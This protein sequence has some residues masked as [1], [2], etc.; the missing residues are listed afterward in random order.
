MKAWKPRGPIGFAGLT[1]FIG[2]TRA[3]GANRAM[4]ACAFMGILGVTVTAGVLITG[5]DFAGG[6]TGGS[7][8][9]NGLT[10][11]LHDGDGKPVPQA[12]VV[13]LPDNYNPIPGRDARPLRRTSTDKRGLYR[14]PGVATGVYNL[15]AKDSLRHVQ[16]L[17][18]GIH[19][20]S[21]AAAATQADGV[22]E[23][24]GTLVIP[25]ADR[26]LPENAQAYV[27][28][29]TYCVFAASKMALGN[30]ALE[31]LAPGTYKELLAMSPDLPDG[32]PITVAGGFRIGPD[33]TTRLNPLQAWL[34]SARLKIDAARIPGGLTEALAGYPLL[35]R[36]G[37]SNFD[38]TQARGGGEDIRFTRA[39]GTRLPHQIEM[40]DAA[41]KTAAIWV[42]LDSLDRAGID[43][44]VTLH[45]GRVDAMDDSRGDQVFDTARGFA[46]V[47]HLGEPATTAAGAYHDATGE[48]AGANPA[49]A[50]APNADTR[51]AAMG[52]FGKAFS[53]GGG[54]LSAALPAGLGGNAG[55]SVTFWM[56]FEMT[57]GRA[58]ILTFG[59]PA[60]NRGFHFLIRADTSAQF[61]PWG[62]SPDSNDSPSAQQ[63]HF[64]LAPYL[65][66]WAQVATVYN[67]ADGML[68]TYVD[69]V[70]MASNAVPGMDIL[71]P[72]GLDIGKH[73]QAVSLLQS[74][75]LGSLDE[76]RVYRGAL[77]ES[78]IRTEYATQKEGAAVLL[79]P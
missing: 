10:G 4:A 1:G 13:L 35:V 8:T 33:S 71:A 77:S 50:A 74:D 5:C 12:A 21:A 48:A 15:E 22:L 53:P 42:R 49:T 25:F 6:T 11:T 58:G 59:Q 36:L 62:V 28:G 76:V 3:T 51:V 26:H 38:F 65:G 19:V 20:D 31:N 63:N 37:A 27:P 43:S 70:K 16:V 72:S 34:H 67:A 23:A 60:L 44:S 66:Q 69:G 56:R 2:L 68:T 7:E 55:F 17:V 54:T 52:G 47:W 9:T 39:D 78:W 30:L 18:Q 64:N 24:P 46:S 73:V 45:W 75:F 41:G 29:T 79:S 57:A 32:G 40:W 14:F 61:G